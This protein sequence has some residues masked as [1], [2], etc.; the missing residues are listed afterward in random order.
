MRVSPANQMPCDTVENGGKLFIV[1][2]QK[3]PL[4]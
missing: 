4:E 3:T 2:I 1:N